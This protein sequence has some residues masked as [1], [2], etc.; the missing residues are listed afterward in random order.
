VLCCGVCCC[1]VWPC[2]ALC[3]PWPVGGFVNSEPSSSRASCLKLSRCQLKNSYVGNNADGVLVQAHRA[4]F[5]WFSY[6]KEVN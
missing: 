3:I 6:S 4:M 2:V 1:G 5:D